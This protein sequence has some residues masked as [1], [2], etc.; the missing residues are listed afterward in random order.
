LELPLQQSGTGQIEI[1]K[2]IR[3]P[4]LDSNRQRD[5]YTR[6]LYQK[7]EG[8]VKIKQRPIK[9]G[10]RTIYRTLLPKRT[11]FLTGTDR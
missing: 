8:S 2:N 6:A 11:H 1:R 7:N 9:M 10:G 5:L 3:N 4:L